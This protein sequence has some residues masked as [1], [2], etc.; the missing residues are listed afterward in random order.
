MG[1]VARLGVD[2]GSCRIGGEGRAARQGPGSGSCGIGGEGIVGA[3]C[4]ARSDR[5]GAAVS[6]SGE[7]RVDL[8]DIL[9]DRADCA[10][11][12]RTSGEG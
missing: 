1:R 3:D 11:T 12:W 10:S 6:K 8:G 2:I 5:C 9:E 7:T 4:G